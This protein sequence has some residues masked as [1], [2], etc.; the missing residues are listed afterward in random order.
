MQEPG[1]PQN[2]GQNGHLKSFGLMLALSALGQEQL[3]PAKHILPHMLKG[4]VLTL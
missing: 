4:E 2:K 1:A 3:V